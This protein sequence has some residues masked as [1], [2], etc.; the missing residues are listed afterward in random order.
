MRKIAKLEWSFLKFNLIQS[1]EYRFNFVLGTIYEL[2]ETLTTLLYFYVIIS[3]VHSIAGWGMKETAFVTSFA[4]FIDAVCT[5]LFV[6]GLAAMPSMIENGKLDFLLLRP[7]NKQFLLSFC[8]PNTTQILN[9]VVSTILMIGTLVYFDVAVSF[10]QVLVFFISAIF[11]VILMYSILSIITSSS[12]WF[13]RI[14]GLWSIVFTFHMA[15]TRPGQIY[16][17]GLR[18]IMTLIIPG[19]V[20]LNVPVNILFSG[21]IH[22]LYTQTLPITVGFLVLSVLVF[23]KGLEK[24]TSAGS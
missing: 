8:S 3:Q 18:I 1:L 19:L 14:G 2:I 6:N 10:I 17:K 22:L 15:A 23:K 13:I 12:F 7:T 5:F 21:D 16:S 24:Y 20:V 11:S 4:Y 9:L